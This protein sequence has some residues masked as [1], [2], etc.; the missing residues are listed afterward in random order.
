MKIIGGNFGVKGSARISQANELVINGTP[1][2]T[3]AKEQVSAVSGHVN[4]E[5]KFGILGF[6]LGFIILAVMLGLLFNVIGVVIAL[7]LAIAGSFYSV[8]KN[9]IEIQFSDN[10]AITLECSARGAK[11]LFALSPK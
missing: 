10:K 5:T 7:V 3:Y 8:K 2:A 1:D 4:K 9:I 6:L 11:K